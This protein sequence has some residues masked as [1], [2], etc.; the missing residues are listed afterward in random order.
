MKK[1]IRVRQF[2][3]L[4]FDLHRV[5]EKQGSAVTWVRWGEK[6]ICRIWFQPLCDQPTNIY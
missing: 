6:W 1:S 4:M 3:L 5:S 2:S